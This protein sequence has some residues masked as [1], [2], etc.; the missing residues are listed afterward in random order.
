MLAATEDVANRQNVIASYNLQQFDKEGVGS[1]QWTLFATLADITDRNPQF[2]QQMQEAVSP[3]S[4]IDLTL[5][6]RGTRTAVC[7]GR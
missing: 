6:N 7:G 4:Q 3:A 1:P 5:S 2:L